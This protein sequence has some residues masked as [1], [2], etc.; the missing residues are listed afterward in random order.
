MTS[1]KVAI[2]S[3]G[4]SGMGAVA[5][6]R[7]SADGY[8]VAILSSSGEGEVL[9]D[10]L[11][12]IFV[13]ENSPTAAGVQSL[14]DLVMDRWG[15]VD[16]LVNSAGHRPIGPVLDVK[17]DDLR[18]GMDVFLTSVVRPTRIVVPVMAEQGTGIIVNIS[19]FAAFEPDA[20]FPTSSIFRSALSNF[21]KLIVDRYA[22]DNIRMHN[23]FPSVMDILPESDRGARIAAGNRSEMGEISSTVAYLVS[24]TATRLAA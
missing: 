9:A 12:G 24:D 5:A 20:R 17:D 15:R 6:R 2:V 3:A 19:T 7:L 16:V 8:Q 10:E 18:A 13:A 4:G 1:Y 11:D 21:S 23:V 14:M 22:A